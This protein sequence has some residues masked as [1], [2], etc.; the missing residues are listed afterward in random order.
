MLFR[1]VV[2]VPDDSDMPLELL[3]EED[4]ANSRLS[5]ESIEAIGDV[6]TTVNADMAEIP[7]L[8]L[9]IMGTCHALF[10]DPRSG[11]IT[12]EHECIDSVSL[13]L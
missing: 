9:A 4:P 3:E 5:A 6:V 7:A 10:R 13:S 2:A 1:G 12:G 8:P 11:S